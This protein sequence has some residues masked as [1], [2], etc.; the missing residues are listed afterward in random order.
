MPLPESTV[1]RFLATGLTEAQRGCWEEN[2]FFIHTEPIHDAVP[3]TREGAGLA[4]VEIVDVPT[5]NEQVVLME[6]GDLLV[7]HSHLRHRSTDNLTD[8]MRAAMV[9][10]YAARGWARA[11]G[12]TTPTAAA[13]EPPPLAPPPADD[14]TSLTASVEPIL[15]ISGTVVLSSVR[16]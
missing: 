16:G 14:K 2:G 6:P 1:G 7:F 13:S 12:P 4:Y 8:G 3:D 10:H 15:D 5:D 9:Y 11:S